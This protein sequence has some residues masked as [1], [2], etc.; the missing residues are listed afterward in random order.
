MTK[1]RTNFAQKKSA[2]A[3]NRRGGFALGI[4]FLVLALIGG[5]LGAIALLGGTSQNNAGSA[6]ERLITNET[7]S[8]LGG[9]QRA[10]LG[11]MTTNGLRVNQVFAYRY[12]SNGTAPPA[13]F[14]RSTN[15]LGPR[16]TWS[17]PQLNVNAYAGTPACNQ[18]SFL[19]EGS[20]TSSGCVL[21][22]TRVW[23]S[24]YGA[25]LTISSTIPAA[26]DISRTATYI[27]Y[28]LPIANKIAAQINNAL[29]GSGLGVALDNTATLSALQKLGPPTTDGDTTIVVTPDAVLAGVTPE[30]IALAKFPLVNGAVRAEGMLLNDVGN[31]YFKTIAAY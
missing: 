31:I 1:M 19:N 16:G 25:G 12:P 7:V 5:I 2:A 14:N 26:G 28:T 3:V 22:F 4:I 18:T 11:M 20:G 8:M 6:D 17:L 9:A 21:Y 23:S 29:W 27:V 13:I 15:L 24:N 30:T 10:Y